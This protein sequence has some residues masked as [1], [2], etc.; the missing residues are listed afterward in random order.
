MGNSPNVMEEKYRDFNVFFKKKYSECMRQYL[1]QEFSRKKNKVN[2]KKDGI[3]GNRSI[4][5]F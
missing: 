4:C 3:N 5:N 2:A 1:N